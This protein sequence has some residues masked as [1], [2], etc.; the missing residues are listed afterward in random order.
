MKKLLFIIPAFNHGGTN[1]SLMHIF[2]FIDKSKYDMDIFAMSDMGPYK[3]SFSSYNILQR[4]LLLASFLGNFREMKRE[5]LPEKLKKMPIKIIYFLL[6]RFWGKLL[7]GFAY[8][9]TARRIEKLNYETI[10]AMEEGPPAYLA[11][12][13]HLPKI[14]WIRC[15]FSR[16]SDSVQ[17]DPQ[18]T[19]ADF[20]HIIC[21]SEYTKRVFVNLYPALKEKCHAIHNVI[22]DKKM[23]RMSDDLSE[24]DGRFLPGIFSIISVGRLDIVKQFHIIPEIAGWLK[25]SGC[26]FRW[27]IIGDGNQ[28]ETILSMVDKF[29]VSDTVFLLGEKDNPYPYIKRSDLLVCTSLS[30]ACP[31]VINE[32]K[33]LHVPVVTTDFG[34]ASEFIEHG[35]NGIITGKDNLKTAIREMIGD[36][37]KHSKIKE[38]LKSFE[39][40]NREI[41]KNITELL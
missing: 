13:I 15:D 3:K 40:P 37:E 19:Y 33:I 4:D 26:E 5:I 20:K 8:K 24:N 35:V 7:L 32:A 28:K 18:Q 29:K 2:S 16:I 22:D 23:L 36:K 30:E 34:S 27:Y 14:A 39:Y 31:H 17:I 6:R 41:L 21:V 38:K 25:K 11:S 12:R 9:R 10:I 1:K